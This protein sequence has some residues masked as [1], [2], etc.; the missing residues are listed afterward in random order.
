MREQKTLIVANSSP[1]TTSYVLE[2]EWDEEIG[3]V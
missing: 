3:T 1:W 2:L